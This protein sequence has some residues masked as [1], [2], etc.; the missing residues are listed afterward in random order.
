MGPKLL[1][2]VAHHRGCDKAVITTS[3]TN[4]SD[5]ALF[6]TQNVSE[7]QVQQA[8][9][10]HSHSA[11]TAQSSKVHNPMAATN[12]SQTRWNSVTIQQRSYNILS[13]HSLLHNLSPSTPNL[14][15][16]TPYSLNV[17]IVLLNDHALDSSKLVA[18]HIISTAENFTIR[19]V[20]THRSF[21]TSKCR[22]WLHDHHAVSSGS[23]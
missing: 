23:M 17:L 2:I 9:I 11:A 3:N 1:L 12:P 5:T 8:K 16:T 4:Q 10:I 13:Y 22:R 19:S 21:I 6:H 7:T 14:L 20:S 15:H 18:F